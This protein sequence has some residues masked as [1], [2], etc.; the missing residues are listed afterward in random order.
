MRKKRSMF[1]RKE[2]LHNLHNGFENG[3][4]RQR[5]PEGI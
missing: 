1:D 2:E 5:C 4:F 3:I